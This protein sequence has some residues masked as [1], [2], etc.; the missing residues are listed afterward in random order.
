[1][2]DKLYKGEE[3]K[4]MRGERK[5]AMVYNSLFLAKWTH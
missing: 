5:R 1:M 4:S 3:D 2:D